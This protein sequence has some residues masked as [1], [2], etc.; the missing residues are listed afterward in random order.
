ML[1]EQSKDYDFGSFR[2]SDINKFILE[3]QKHIDYNKI[4]L[5][6]QSLDI[7][8]QNFKEIKIKQLSIPMCV[9][10]MF[11]ILKDQKSVSQYV[12]WF[13]KFITT[14]NTNEEYLKYCE[15]G[16]SSSEMVKG[17]LDYFMKA[18]KAM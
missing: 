17:R 13:K 8:D 3:Y 15:A 5:V 1:T 18:I 2:N 16:T 12:I 11:R 4:K 14:Y 9:Y 6:K 7:L 10:G